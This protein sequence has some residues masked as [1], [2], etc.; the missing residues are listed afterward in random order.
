MSYGLRIHQLALACVVVLMVLR[1]M[2]LRVLSS[3]R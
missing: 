2:I 1:M 3:R